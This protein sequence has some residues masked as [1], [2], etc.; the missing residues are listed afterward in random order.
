[1]HITCLPEDKT[2]A[3]LITVQANHTTWAEAILLL[4]HSKDSQLQQQLEIL[5]RPQ[6]EATQHYMSYWGSLGP[7]LFILR[8]AANNYK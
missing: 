4:R 3:L 5:G 2:E 1:M 8:Q 7:Q 6:C